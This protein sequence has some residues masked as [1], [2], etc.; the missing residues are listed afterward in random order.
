MQ[1]AMTQISCARIRTIS[2]HIRP[3]LSLRSFRTGKVEA[4]DQKAKRLR[5]KSSIPSHVVNCL[6]IDREASL[7]MGPSKLKRIAIL[8][9]SEFCYFRQQLSQKLKT[10]C[11]LTGKI[12]FPYKCDLLLQRTCD[13]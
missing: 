4:S 1:S 12:L 8:L 9:K 7:N 3:M 5:L 10:L 11:I 6:S 2:G 13:N